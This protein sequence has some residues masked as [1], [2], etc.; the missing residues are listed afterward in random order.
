VLAETAPMLPAEKPRYL[1]GVGFPRDIAVAVAAGIDMFD[2]T[3]PTRNGRNAY[4][5]AAT[6]AI[7]VKN[8]KFTRETGP[9]EEGC[10]CYACMNF[11]CGAIRHFFFAGEMLGPLLVSVHNMRFYQRFMADIRQAIALGTFGRFLVE[12]P[13]CQ[14]GPGVKKEIGPCRGSDGG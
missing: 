5:F 3:L 7:R 2:C 1:M 14:L 9:L 11:S 12:D 13:R 4:A 8:A 6:G 10:D